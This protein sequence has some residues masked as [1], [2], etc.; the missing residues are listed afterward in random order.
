VTCEALYHLLGGRAG[1]W[2]PAT[3]RHEGDV[4][5]YLVHSSGLV[6]DPTRA[7]FLRRPDYARGRGRGF[8]TKRPSRA[9][10]RLIL[11]LLYQDDKRPGV[12][13]RAGRDG[14]LPA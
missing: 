6:L 12:R 7:Q 3:V 10:A 9:A 13:C 5:W 2:K 8:L 1:G 14:G 4:H 11:Q